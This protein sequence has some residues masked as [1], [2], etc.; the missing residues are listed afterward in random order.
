[1]GQVSRGS[2]PALSQR[3]HPQKLEFTAGV[4]LSAASC[5]PA[6]L[7]AMEIDMSDDKSATTGP[8][9]ARGVP[10]DEIA[11]GTMLLG[12]VGEHPVLL[13]RRGDAFFAIGATCTH[14]GG[15]LAEGLMVD[16]T[17]RCPWH[18]A[19]FSLI[20]GEA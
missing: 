11:D 12:H 6:A 17:V 4:Q 5:I 19:C 7:A 14:Y 2:Q 10:T 3:I 8:E 18:H 9:L 13:A 20:T 16:G 15:P 1:M